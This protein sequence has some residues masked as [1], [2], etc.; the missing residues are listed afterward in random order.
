MPKNSSPSNSKIFP[1]LNL[2]DPSYTPILMVLLLVASFLLG[3]LTTKLSY[4]QQGNVPSA[5]SAPTNQQAQAQPGKKVNVDLGHLPLQGSKDAK[6]S[7]VEFADFQCPFCEK[8]F[9]DVKPSI[10]SDYVNKGLVKFTFRHYAFLGQESTWASEAAECANEQGRFWDYH[11]YLYNHQGQE[12]SG[13]FSK[14]NLE[15]FA[16]DLGL[17]TQQFNSCLDSDKYAKAVSDDTTAGQ[18]AGVTGTPSIFVNGQLI[19]GAQPYSA[20]KT[21]ID[22]ALS[23]K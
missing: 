2:N 6:V 9:K 20:F 23:G 14:A 3:A 19:V 8:W 22:Q 15:K 4:T 12:N 1:K 11:D 17:N 16:S 13:A 5:S 7:V 10:L 21:V 18:N